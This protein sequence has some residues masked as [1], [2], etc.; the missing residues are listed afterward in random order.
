MGRDCRHCSADS[1]TRDGTPL[2]HPR[3]ASARARVAVDLIVCVAT[4]QMMSE[5]PLYA[6]IDPGSGALIWQAILAAFFGGAFYFRRFLTRI[7]FWKKSDK[8]E[9]D[10]PSE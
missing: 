9:T 4:L 10:Q 5:A 2:D 3:P 6:Y 7:T 8:T 1:S